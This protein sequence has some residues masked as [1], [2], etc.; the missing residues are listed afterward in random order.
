M[1]IIIEKNALIAEHKFSGKG[2]AHKYRKLFGLKTEFSLDESYQI[3]SKKF[4]KHELE[5]YCRKYGFSLKV[6]RSQLYNDVSLD[7]RY[8]TEIRYTT[9]AIVQLSISE[10]GNAFYIRNKTLPVIDRITDKL[11]KAIDEAILEKLPRSSIS[12]TYCNFQILSNGVHINDDM[13]DHCDGISRFEDYGMALLKNMNEYCGMALI[14]H[15]KILDYLKNTYSNHI[16]EVT[17]STN[18]FYSEEGV[19]LRYRFNKKVPEKSFT[20][21]K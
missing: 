17:I 4:S 9:E 15:D 12:S 21:W 10:C 20:E 13:W 1:N 3:F 16:D 5:S 2:V 8:V 11:Y 18:L 6:D 7:S 19:E 14:V